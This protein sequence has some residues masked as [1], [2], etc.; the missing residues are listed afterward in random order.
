MT[1]HHPLKRFLTAT[2]NLWDRAGTLRH[3]RETFLS[4]IKCGTILLGANVYASSTQCK[5]VY[6]TCKSRFCPSC[7]H[8]ATKAWQEELEAILPDIPFVDLTFTMPGE[9]WP[10]LQDNRDL[11][12]CIPTAG[13][14]A[15]ETWAQLKY[16]VR[17]FIVIV[18][19]T[20]GGF[21]DFAPHLHIMVSAGGLRETTHRWIEQLIFD[22]GELMRAWRFAVSALL[23]Q[24]R[25][26]QII[27]PT[28]FGKDI[29][30]VL[31]SQYQREWQVHVKL[32][33]SK[34][35]ILHYDG[36]YIR[37]PPIA[38]RR[39]KIFPD[40]TVE[41]LA[42]DT[43]NEA[44]RSLRFSPEKFLHLLMQHVQ[45]EG[46]HGMRYFG[47]LA[48]RSARTLDAVFALLGQKKRPRPLRTDWRTLMVKSF[49]KDPLIDDK[50]ERMQPIGRVGR[51]WQD[52]SEHRS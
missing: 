7:G 6:F 35:D 1:E 33:M 31:K 10:I 49:G 46:R 13:A 9:L 37:R 40:N 14:N 45:D 24:A 25:E 39:L 26:R 8:R 16:G 18:Q 34:A 15:I 5:L 27:R 29:E 2:R 28:L 41:Y 22:E 52:M 11:L 3:I 4:I 30:D 42:K 36:R 38:Q 51:G 23:A 32:A 17:L 20:F 47:L 44:W 48:P 43:R 19:Q 12:H 50:G 21:L